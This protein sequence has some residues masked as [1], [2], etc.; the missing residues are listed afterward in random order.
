M[1]E[2]AGSTPAFIGVG[3]L[4]T[5]HVLSHIDAAEQAA[6]AGV[7]L[8]PMTY[9]ALT[10]DD[11]FDLYR[12]VTQ[13]TELPV[14]VY[15]NPG[16]TH[17]TFTIDLYVRIAELTGTASIKIP[18]APTNP[19]E[20][21]EHIAAIRAV[22]PEHVTIGVS[23]DAFAATGLNAGC[24]AWY[25]VIG[26]TLPG[27]ALAITRAAQADRTGE[28]VSESDHLAPLWALFAEFG[29]QSARDRCDRRASRLF[30][31]RAPAAANP[32]PHR[33]TAYPCRAGGGRARTC[34]TRRPRPPCWVGWALARYVLAATLV[35]P[36]DGGAVV[37]IVLLGHATGHPGWMAGLLGVPTTQQDF[38][39]TT[40]RNAMPLIPASTAVLGICFKPPQAL[41]KWCRWRRRQAPSSCLSPHPKRQQP[42]P[43]HMV[44]HVCLEVGVVVSVQKLR[45]ST[46]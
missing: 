16:T 36:A 44:S 38:R 8:A 42:P 30:T 32:G 33:D 20:A 3:D 4:R 19:E 35:R 9:Q 11:V 34:P 18:G 1:V 15:D 2:N 14:I 41:M 29:G 22:V 28:A 37:V 17:F 7:L 21:R 12:T 23:G 24:E 25:S 46:A 45:R 13:H 43:P 5:S 26:G 27:P 40:A 39:Q 6:A 10:A 31:T